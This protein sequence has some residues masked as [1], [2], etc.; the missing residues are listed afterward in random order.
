MNGTGQ[1][2]NT[3]RENV[4]QRLADYLSDLVGVGFSGVQDFTIEMN[5]ETMTASNLEI[6]RELGVTRVSFGWQTSIARLRKF[7]ALVPSEETLADRLGDLERLGYPLIWDIMY[8][9]PGQSLEDWDVDLRR[10]IDLG[11]A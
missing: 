2:T 6:C 1:R 8:A 11:A 9:L 10:S 3:E 7:L 5:L 4:Q